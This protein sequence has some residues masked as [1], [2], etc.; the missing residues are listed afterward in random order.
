MELKICSVGGYSEVGKNMTAL[1]FGDDAVICDMGIYLPKLIDF[2]EE[3]G[4][5]RKLKANE[6]IKMGAIPDDSVISSWKNKV[7]AIATT[8][9][10]LDHIAAMP[11]LASKYN[12]PI[13]GTAYTLEVLK[14]LYR[15]QSVNSRNK[16]KQLNSGNRIKINKNL[17]IEFINITHSTLQCVLIAMH[18]SEGVFIYANDFKLDNHPVIGNKPDFK[19]LKQLGKSGQVKALIFDSLY[20]GR[21]A[22]TP[23]EKVAREMLKDVM[24]GTQNEGHAIIAT[25]FASHIAR[26]K[27]IIEF[28]QKLNRKIIFCGRSLHKYVTAAEKIGMVKFS[29]QVEIAGYARQVKKRLKEISEKK[30]DEYLIVCTGNQAEP[31]AILTRMVNGD[32]PWNFNSEDHVIF[33]CKTIP[34]EINLAN[35]ALMERK[36]KLKHVRLFKDIH[37]SGHSSKED[38]RDM[39]NMLKPEHLIPSHGGPEVLNAG[40]ALGTEMGYQLGKNLHILR[41]NLCIN[42]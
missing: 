27:S 15:D 1:K 42:I 31:R 34:A 29:N 23:S 9:C 21:D 40:A 25:T 18:T 17:D 33:S 5:I 38:M 37:T 22:K 4:D 7:K 3:G 39:I 8:H 24:L 19:R 16:L 36:L 28:G 2:E 26:L 11:Y 41:D 35:R 14:T 10:H 13:I 32:L 12:A 6:L 30:R 20:A